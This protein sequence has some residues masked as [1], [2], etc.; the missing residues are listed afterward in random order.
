MERILELTGAIPEFSSNESP[1]S[2][3]RNM[4]KGTARTYFIE[5][6]RRLVSSASTAAENTLSAMVV[7]VCTL[8]DYKQKGYAT[9]CMQ[10]LC[11]DVLSEGKELCL[12]YDN[13]KAES[14]YKRLGFE[15][16]GR[17]TM[18]SL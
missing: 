16:I 12:F 1:E 9:K 8:E 10:K 14:I 6:D 17:W 4:E 11:T 5:E 3:R 13:P 7:G 18:Y 2:K 15:N